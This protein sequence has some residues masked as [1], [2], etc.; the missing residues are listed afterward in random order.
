MSRPDLPAR[1]ALCSLIT[2]QAVMLAALFSGV[3]PHPPAATP[4]FGIA[5]FLA[6]ALAAASS[7]LVLGPHRGRAGPILSAVSALTALVSFGPQKFFDPQFALIWPAVLAG[8][9][10]AAVLLTGGLVRMLRKTKGQS[11]VA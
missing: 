3:A 1:A 6:A 10:A 2:L 8:Q 4:L 7:A 5:P 11:N 9:F